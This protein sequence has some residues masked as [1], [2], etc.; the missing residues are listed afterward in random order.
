VHLDVEHP[1]LTGDHRCVEQRGEALHVGGGRHGQQTEVG[2][3]RGGHV[4]GEG[5]AEVGREV[6]FVHLVEDH[7]AHAGE[8]GI[9]LEA[10]G[11]DALGEHLDSGGGPMRRSSRVW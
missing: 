3:N 8:L 1:A 10:A 5:Q 6:S 4:E 11:E 2:T 9:V 7:Q